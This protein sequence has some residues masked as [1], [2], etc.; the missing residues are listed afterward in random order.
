M[1][2]TALDCSDRL[3]PTHGGLGGSEGPKALTVAEQPLHGCMITL[4]EIV[5]PLSVDVPDAVEMGV[6]AMIDFADHP[7]VGGSLVC[8]NN[9]RTMEPHAFNRLVEKSLGCPRVASCGKAEVDH[10]A[11]RIDSSPQIA[12]FAADSD[13]GFVDVP[14]DTGSAQMPLRA[15]GQFRPKLDDPAVDRRPINSDLTL[16]EQIDDVLIG[17]G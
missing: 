3:Y 5:S 10:L 1:D 11:I 17:Q 7:P 8:H 15:L 2:I 14:I 9:D 12:P 6:V 13:I 4:Y 16:C